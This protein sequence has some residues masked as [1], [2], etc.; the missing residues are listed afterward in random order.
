[1]T[2]LI[3]IPGAFNS[4]EYQNDCIVLVPNHQSHADYLALGVNF[5]KI[6][7]TPVYVAGGNNLNI[8]PI[9]RIFRKCGCFFIRRSFHNNLTY[10]MTLEG[11]LY[12]LLK[13]GKMVQF[14]L[15]GA[16]AAMENCV[17]HVS[18]SILCFWQLTRN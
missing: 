13:K 5:F 17:L 16:E 12:Y 3:L 15:R 6:F 9:G 4:R 1:M 11:Y 18:D 7:S 14:F 2:K 10:K 8:F